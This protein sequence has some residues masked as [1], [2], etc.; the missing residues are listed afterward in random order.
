MLDYELETSGLGF[1]LTFQTFLHGYSDG[2]FVE[3]SLISSSCLV[4]HVWDSVPNRSDDGSISCLVLR[5]EMKPKNCYIFLFFFYVF[6]CF[7]F[8]I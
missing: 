7:F 2:C 6:F 1:F 5:V 8:V 4:L 3:E